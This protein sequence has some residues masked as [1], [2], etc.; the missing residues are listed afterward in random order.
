MSAGQISVR[1]PEL[2]KVHAIP[3]PF[4]AFPNWARAIPFFALHVACIS[5]FFTSVHLVDWIMCGTLYVIRMFGITGGYHRYFAHKS[6]KTSRPFQFVLG[7]LGCMSLQKGPLWWAA[8]HRLHHRYS[9]TEEDVHSP[10]TKTVWHAHVGWVLETANDDTRWDVIK[11]FQD[12]PELR[13]LNAMH[14]VPGIL[15]GVACFFISLAFGGTGWGGVSVGF[16]LSTI[17]VYHGTF[18]INSM[19]HLFGNRRYETTD[20]SRNSMILA[21]ITMG[22]GW[23]NNHHHYMAAARQGFFWWEIDM[24][25]YVLKAL[26]A[27]GLIWDLK[28]PPKVMLASEYRTYRNI[29]K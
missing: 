22:E 2:P 21:L 29:A 20:R 7:W 8:H 15:L 12:V 28:Q 19:A 18:L 24:S 5:I 9:D 11:D 13:W 16:L 10:I 3:K 23:H 25:Y 4:F 17:L 1:V 27:V 26:S 6:Y 14:W